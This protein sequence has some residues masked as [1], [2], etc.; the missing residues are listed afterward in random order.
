[1]S[2]SF[3]VEL[4]GF[5]NLGPSWLWGLRRSIQSGQ[6]RHETSKNIKVSDAANLVIILY[7]ELNK[8]KNKVYQL[9]PCA[10]GPCLRYSYEKK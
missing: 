6:L 10:S 2:S 8:K 3:R 5:I 7:C 1:M 9:H 4:K